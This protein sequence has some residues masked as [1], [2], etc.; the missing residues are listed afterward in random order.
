MSYT[1]E[2]ARGEVKNST[3]WRVALASSLAKWEQIAG[4]DE[5]TYPWLEFCGFCFVAENRGTYCRGC[6]ATCICADLCKDAEDILEMLRGI[7]LPEAE[8]AEDAE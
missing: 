7:D 5:V 6:P 4:G 1:M 3:D 8:D 2:E